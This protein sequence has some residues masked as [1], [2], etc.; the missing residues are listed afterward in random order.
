VIDTLSINLNRTKTD[1][2]KD[3]NR[4]LKQHIRKSSYKRQFKLWK[5]YLMVYDLYNQIQ[6]YSKI[7]EILSKAIPEEE[8]LFDEKNVKNYYRA[9]LELSN[10]GYKLY[11]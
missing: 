10:G 2:V 6:N 1:I 4:V 8:N 9:F 3:I 7:S 11:I 5:Y